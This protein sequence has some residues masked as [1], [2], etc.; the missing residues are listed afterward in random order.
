MLDFIFYFLNNF[1]I[2][3]IPYLL[4]SNADIVFLVVLLLFS[5][6]FDFFRIYAGLT[7]SLNAKR[8]YF[9]LF[10]RQIENEE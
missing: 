7:G 1:T 2:F 9:F 8:K 6:L 10:S 4:G 5:L 3:L